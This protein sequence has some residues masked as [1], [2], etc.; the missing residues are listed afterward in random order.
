M[1]IFAALILVCLITTLTY[2]SA[3]HHDWISVLLGLACLVALG[4][5]A[6]QDIKNDSL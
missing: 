2:L 1:V 5:A 3:I 6:L 4:W